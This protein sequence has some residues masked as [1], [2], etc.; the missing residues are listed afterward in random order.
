M[1]LPRTQGGEEH[2]SEQPGSRGVG[3]K[4]VPPSLVP[5]LFPLPHRGLGEKERFFPE[6]LKQTDCQWFGSVHKTE[7]FIKTCY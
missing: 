7:R 5:D 2:P 4:P 1:A 3:C 6:G